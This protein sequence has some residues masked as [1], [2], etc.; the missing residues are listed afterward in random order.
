MPLYGHLLSGAL[1]WVLLQATHF[2]T[3]QAYRARVE[4]QWIS[5]P[6]IGLSQRV[7]DQ[8]LPRPGYWPITWKRRIE[9]RLVGAS[10][11]GFRL[12]WRLSVMFPWLTFTQES[13][14]EIPWHR[15]TYFR[16][17]ERWRMG[18]SMT[19]SQWEPALCVRFLWQGPPEKFIILF[20]FTVSCRS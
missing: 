2:S 8:A 13:L 9:H 20:L 16:R 19:I 18:A 3:W 7:P 1:K 11:A 14:D 15:V 17:I 5:A 12:G 6:M 4:Y 10:M